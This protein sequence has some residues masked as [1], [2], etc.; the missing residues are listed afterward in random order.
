MVLQNNICNAHTQ[1]SD[2]QSLLHTAFKLIPLQSPLKF[3][4]SAVC[5]TYISHWVKFINNTI[6]LS[7]CLSF[8]CLLLIMSKLLI[9]WIQHEL[10]TTDNKRTSVFILMYCSTT[11]TLPIGIQKLHSCQS[12]S[13]S[14]NGNAVWLKWL[15]AVELNLSFGNGT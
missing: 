10:V 5:F 13:N 11:D 4:C 3:F 2:V 8:Y 6:T 14:Q 12:L 15:C 7:R 9:F 1:I